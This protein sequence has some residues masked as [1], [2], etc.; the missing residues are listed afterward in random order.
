MARKKYN[1]KDWYWIVGGNETQVFSSLRGDYFPPTDPAYVEWASDGTKVSRII[2]NTDLGRL[3]AMYA[4]RPV[5]AVVLD[6]FK[7]AQAARYTPIDVTPKV[8]HFILN[9]VRGL[10]GKAPLT[11]EQFRQAVKDRM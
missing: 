8:V 11:F 7:E 1:P 2:D 3:L 6:A 9:E 5:N 10:Q 4:V